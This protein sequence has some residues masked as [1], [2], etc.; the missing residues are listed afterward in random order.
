M[1][2]K[3][4]NEYIWALTFT[5]KELIIVPS[6]VITLKLTQRQRPLSNVGTVL[7]GEL[8]TRPVKAHSAGEG[9]VPLV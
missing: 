4:R 9:E 6:P 2:T 8:T 5:E 3:I 1:L 7:L